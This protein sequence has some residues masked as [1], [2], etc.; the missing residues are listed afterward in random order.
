[1]AKF[2]SITNSA[3]TFSGASGTWAAGVVSGNVRGWNGTLDVQKIDA[4]TRSSGGWREMLDGI[5]S[6][7]GQFRMAAD[8]T[9]ALTGDDGGA[10]TVKLNLYT[11][12]RKISG[13]F[14]IASMAVDGVNHDQADL[15]TVTFNIES[16]GAVTIA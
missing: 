4:T 14:R 3:V 7:T 8:D 6:F 9:T 2:A 5:K 11:T 15:P 16:T 1:M 10:P 12:S 13:T